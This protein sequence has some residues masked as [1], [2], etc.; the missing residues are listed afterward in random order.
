SA[1]LQSN[2]LLCIQLFLFLD[3]LSIKI[4]KRQSNETIV[5]HHNVAYKV[6]VVDCNIYVKVEIGIMILKQFVEVPNRGKNIE[7]NQYYVNHDS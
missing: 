6:Q 1:Q 3:A 5:N 7:W 4:R 2:R